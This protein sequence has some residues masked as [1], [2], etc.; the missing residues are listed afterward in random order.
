MSRPPMK[1]EPPVTNAL[2]SRSVSMGGPYAPTDVYSPISMLNAGACRSDIRCMA[3]GPDELSIRCKQA[4]LDALRALGGRAHRRQI[5][6]TAL[7]DGRLSPE[8]LQRPG[9]PSRPGRS[10][11][12]HYLEWSLTWLKRDGIVRADGGAVWS[13][14]PD[15]VAAPGRPPEGPKELR[16]WRRRYDAYRRTEHWQRRRER[17][18]EDAGFRC[19]LDHRHDGPFDVHHNSYERLGFEEPADLIVL[20]R[21]CHRRHHGHEAARRRRRSA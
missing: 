1:P 13:L 10:M 5:L 17:A 4:T 9:P 18:L 3:R 7:D 19:Q 12:D 14:V 2:W 20:C 11:V 8:D 16:E 21:E 15:H 6:A